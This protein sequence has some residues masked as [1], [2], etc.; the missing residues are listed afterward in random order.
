MRRV[1]NPTTRIVLCNPVQHW[2]TVVDSQ[3]RRMFKARLP[4]W[5]ATI[6][7]AA[8]LERHYTAPPV[9]VEDILLEDIRGE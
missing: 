3:G 4:D 6:A 7:Y 2:V 8:Q 5:R 1:I 9:T